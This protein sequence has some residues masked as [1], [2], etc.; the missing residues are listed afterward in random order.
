MELD[1]IEGEDKGFEP[2]DFEADAQAYLSEI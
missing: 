1:M 2:V